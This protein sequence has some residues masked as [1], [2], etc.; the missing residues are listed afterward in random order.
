[1]DLSGPLNQ[2]PHKTNL[3][4]FPQPKQ[5]RRLTLKIRGMAKNPNRSLALKSLDEQIGALSGTV[6]RIMEQVEVFVQRQ[7]KS[8]RI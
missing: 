5:L 2:T 8:S 4:Q 7:A 6:S 3:Q 1:M